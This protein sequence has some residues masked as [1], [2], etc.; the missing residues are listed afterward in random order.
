MPPSVGAIVVPSELK[1]WV[2]VSRL[3]AVAASPS[4]VTYGLA[5]TC[6]IV[7]PAASTKKASKNTAY[8]LFDAGKNSA[9]PAAAIV[10]PTTAPL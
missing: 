4:T 6:K 2:S 8:P 3:D 1:A 9:Q 5:A 10:K 7:M